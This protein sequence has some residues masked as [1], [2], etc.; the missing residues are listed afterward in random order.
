[1]QSTP[2][3]WETGIFFDSL[4]FCEAYF[5]FDRLIKATRQIFKVL[6]VNLLMEKISQVTTVIGSLPYAEHSKENMFDGLRLQIEAG[7]DYPCYP[8]LMAMAEQFLDPL[9]ERVEG[10]Q[11][12]GKVYELSED[13]KI[14]SAPLALECGKI[15]VEF[16]DQNPELRG[17]I[18][19]MKACLTGPITLANEIVIAESKA[20]GKN[21][22]IYQEPRAVMS[23][24]I[25]M[26]LAALVN[27]I[28]LEY[29][30][31]GFNLI[32]I[33]E[34]VLGLLVGRRALFH[35]TEV[36]QR[37]INRALQ[38]L[39][40]YTSVHVCGRISPAVAQLLA[41][42]KAKI[43]D[44]EFTSGQNEKT[45]TKELLEDNNKTLAVGVIETNVKY[46][47]DAAI[48]DYI[49]SVDEL[50]S[51]IQ[52]YNE[53]FGAENLIFKPDCG[54]GPLYDTFKEDGLVIAKQKLKNL[55]T[56]LK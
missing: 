54:F 3:R 47:K 48:E 31:M 27:S 11:R 38:D 2:D 12:V 37:V 53:K 25:L 43:L 33:D 40:C 14:P 7:V 46:K 56:A 23:E 50:R 4:C 8:Q 22:L 21:P 34:P 13:A 16:F 35:K 5:H 41:S 19:G 51:R 44:H 52:K 9:A 26:E 10:F 6:R 55:T 45:F 32:S 15:M 29:E 28:A 49:E 24:E 39:S 42:S 30:K 18:K 20:G 1:M 36:Y 17:K